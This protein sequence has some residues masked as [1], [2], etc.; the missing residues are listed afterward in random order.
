[1][2]LLSH[3][4]QGFLSVVREGTVH[5][6]ADKLSLTQTAVTQRIRSLEGSLETTLFLRSRRGMQLTPDGEALLRYCLASEELEGQVFSQ[7][8][9]GG[10]EKTVSITIVGPTSIMTSRIVEQCKPIYENWPQLNLHLII[11]DSEERINQVRRGLAQMAIVRPHQVPNEMDSKMIKHDQY[12]LVAASAWKGRKLRDILS[13]ERII[14]FHENDPTTLNYLKSFDLLKFINRPRLFINENRAL[15]SSFISGIGYGT[16]TKEI[17]K[18]FLEKGKLIV[19]NSDHTIK[20]P[21]ALTWYP[22]P[23]MPKYF[24]C[25]IQAIK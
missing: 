25:I 11:D 7:I 6:A 23:E 1:M 15:I 8:K 20:D 18:P 21:L 16:L 22:R 13:Q 24:H 4:L 5:A 17:A 2:R 10:I 3:H 12:V 19:L 9:K 14:D